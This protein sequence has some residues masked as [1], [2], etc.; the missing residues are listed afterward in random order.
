MNNRITIIK[1]DSCVIVDGNT[2]F[3]VNLDFL[4][5]NIRIVQWYNTYGEVEYNDGTQNLPITDFTPYM[6]AYN[7]WNTSYQANTDRPETYYLKSNWLESRKYKLSETP[8]L[9]RYTTTIPPKQHYSY[10][11]WSEKVNNWVIDSELKSDYDKNLCKQIA[12]GRIAQYDWIMDDT[13]TPKLLNKQD[14]FTYR[15]KLRLLILNP[16]E[17]PTWPEVPQE[18]WEN[19]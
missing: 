10:Y 8:D 6:Q 3:N 5:S 2:Q 12:K 16:V 9:K 13:T 7:N 4:A 17:N 14:F 11:V 15:S 18:V 19:E 1:P